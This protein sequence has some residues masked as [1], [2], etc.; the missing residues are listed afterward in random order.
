MPE[1]QM[2]GGSTMARRQA[3]LTR[4]DFVPMA[5]SQARV[6][7]GFDEGHM[8][9]EALQLAPQ[10]GQ[11]LSSWPTQGLAY[12][13]GLAVPGLAVGCYLVS[14]D[15]YNGPIHPVWQMMSELTGHAPEAGQGI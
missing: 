12:F 5:V 13:G 1:G 2:H 7:Q 11:H 4:A 14:I 8:L 15:G 6:P 3:V 9:L 10:G